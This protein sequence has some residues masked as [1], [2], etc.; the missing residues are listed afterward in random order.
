MSS[1]QL[2]ESYRFWDVVALW[3]RETLQHEEVVAR[4]LAR[5][6]IRDGLRFVSVDPKWI[7]PDADNAEFH[8]YPYVGYCAK[9]GTPL[10]VLRASVLQ[11]LL[12][13]VERAALPSRK[14]LYDLFVTR[15]DFRKW[16]DATKQKPP[17]FW[18]AAQESGK[19]LQQSI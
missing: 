3:A 14:L 19:L 2:V 12:S 16:L 17:E 13:I 5:G 10:V 8:G 18:F 6:V 1:S 7:K 11:H 9:Q 15:S 4:A